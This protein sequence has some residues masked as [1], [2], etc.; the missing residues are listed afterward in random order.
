MQEL[1]DPIDFNVSEELCLMMSRIWTL[2]HN[3]ISQLPLSRRWRK[4][5]QV[6]STAAQVTIRISSAKERSPSLINRNLFQIHG[7][8]FPM[9][10]VTVVASNQQPQSNPIKVC[11][12]SGIIGKNLEIMR[13]RRVA[14]VVSL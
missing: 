4:L 8:I 11:I 5:A 12:P 2:N 13:V 14:R 10:V 9:L 6:T 7:R 1:E 3:L